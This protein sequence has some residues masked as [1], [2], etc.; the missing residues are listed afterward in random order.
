MSPTSYQTAPPRVHV[1]NNAAPGGGHLEARLI[2]RDYAGKVKLLNREPAGA[3][4]LWA[5]ARVPTAGGPEL[6][7][8]RSGMMRYTL[9]P[10][11]MY[12]N[13]SRPIFSK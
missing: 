6:G 5:A 8:H 4:V 11:R 2:F 10:G 1:G 13:R 9:S 7:H 3:L 12:P